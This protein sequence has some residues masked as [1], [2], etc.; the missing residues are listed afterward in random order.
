V[1][2]VKTHEAGKPLQHPVG[3]TAVLYDEAWL[4][5]TAAEWVSPLAQISSVNNQGKVIINDTDHSY[6]WS[7]MLA[8]GPAGWRKWAWENF[9]NGSMGIFMDPYLISGVQAGRNNPSNCA[10]GVCTGPVDPQW[11]Q[12]RNNMGY[13]LKYA[14][15][16][17]LVKMTPQGVLSSTGH[18]LA[19]TPAVGAEYLVYTANGGSFTVD[20]SAMPS[21]RTLNVEW[22]DPSTGTTYPAGAVAAGASRSFTPPFT[23][24]AVLYLVD[25]AGHN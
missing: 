10:D 9:T 4:Y 14:N 12:V 17:D 16:M 19:Q 13:T 25:S 2:I 22:L 1:N 24:D 21:S 8:D 6:N 5:T 20:L 3:V 7:N 11:E 15:Q 18:C 23:G